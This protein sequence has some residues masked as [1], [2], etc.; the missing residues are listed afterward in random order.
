MLQLQVSFWVEVVPRL[1]SYQELQPS[2]SPAPMHTSHFKWNVSNQRTLGPLTCPQITGF[3]MHVSHSFSNENGWRRRDDRWLINCYVL[4]CKQ[5]YRKP[6]NCKLFI[7]LPS[8][9][10]L[11]KLFQPDADEI[12]RNRNRPDEIGCYSTFQNY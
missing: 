1:N 2:Y 10:H 4:L 11:S 9:L 5:M 3:I 8:L 7:F 12:G 6:G